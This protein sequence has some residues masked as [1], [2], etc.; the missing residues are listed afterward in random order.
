MAN[1][2]YNR[3]KLIM[4]NSTLDVV[5]DVLQVSLHTS[6]Y[7]AVAEHNFMNEVTNEVAGTG[8]VGGFGG[9]GRKLLASPAVVQDDTNDYAKFTAANIVWTAVDGF[10]AA[11]AIL[12]KKIT[13]DALSPLIGKYDGGFPKTANGGDLNYNWD[14]THGVLTLE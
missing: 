11:Q 13:S 4:L 2:K 6:A 1:L 12:S 7:V 5:S 3:G 9:S 10:T 8:Y 14:P